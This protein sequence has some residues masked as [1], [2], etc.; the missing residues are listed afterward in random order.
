[1]LHVLLYCLESCSLLILVILPWLWLCCVVIYSDNYSTI[2]SDY[3]DTTKTS[4]VPEVDSSFYRMTLW[5]KYR[6]SYNDSFVITN[7]INRAAWFNKEDLRL[8]VKKNI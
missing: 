7:A 4:T 5:G 3:M 8:S 2:L 1:M 6:R